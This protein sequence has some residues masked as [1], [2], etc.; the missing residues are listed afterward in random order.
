[1]IFCNIGFQRIKMVMKPEDPEPD[2]RNI[3]AAAAYGSGVG[4]GTHV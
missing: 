3:V 1:M 2:D 4:T